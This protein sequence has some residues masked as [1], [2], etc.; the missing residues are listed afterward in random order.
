MQFTRSCIRCRGEYPRGEY[1]DWDNPVCRECLQIEDDNDLKRSVKMGYQN[2]K[3]TIEDCVFNLLQEADLTQREIADCTD[4]IYTSL[5]PTLARLI[6]KGKIE[7]YETGKLNAAGGPERKYRKATGEGSQEH[8]DFIAR[9]VEIPSQGTVSEWQK[10]EVT[11]SALSWIWVL[12][13]HEKVNLNF[14][15]GI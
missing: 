3:P 5:G 2:K 9:D 8:A 15:N 11:I 13:D 12:F 6:R 14:I 4:F 7:F 10:M 1:D